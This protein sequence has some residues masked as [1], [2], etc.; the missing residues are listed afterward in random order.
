MRRKSDPFLSV[1]TQFIKIVSDRVKRISV[2]Y[3]LN[4]LLCNCHSIN[5]I[6][7]V[8]IKMHQP[9]EE[10]IY[11]K[12]L[13]AAHVEEEDHLS[14]RIHKDIDRIICD[15]RKEHSADAPTAPGTTVAEDN[16]KAQRRSQ[17]FSQRPGTPGANLLYAAWY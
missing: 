5:T 17:F 10:E 1:P 8:T 12:T 13:E 15:I 2:R 14:N 6:G 3:N 9:S 7:P 16:K 4:S 11:R